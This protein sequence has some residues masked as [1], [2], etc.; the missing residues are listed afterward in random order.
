MGIEEQL[1]KKVEPD[2]PIGDRIVCDNRLG[3]T[4]DNNTRRARADQGDVHK[5]RDVNK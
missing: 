5:K 3:V 4:R 1:R 2:S